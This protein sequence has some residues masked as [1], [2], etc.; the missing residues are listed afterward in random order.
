MAV[1]FCDTNCELNYKLAKEYDL[2]V[3]RMPY[4]LEGIES[5]FDLGENTDFQEF[6]RKVRGGAMPITSGLNETN[7][8]E[9]FEPFFQAGEEIL[10]ISFSSKMS[11]TFEQMDKA[12]KALREK[13]PNVRFER[14]DTKA[15]SMSAGISVY[16]AAKMF[17]EGKTIDEII[18]FLTY[19]APRVNATCTVDD[20]KHLVKGGRLSAAAAFVG[21]MLKL[22]PII[23]LSE[24]GVLYPAD[25]VISRNKALKTLVNDVVNRVEDIDK[26]PIVVLN[27]DC[28]AE[29]DKM[30]SEIK[31]AKP[32]ADIWSYDVGPVVGTHCGPGTLAVCFVAENRTNFK[33][34]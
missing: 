24:D 31:E 27:A 29:A 34:A 6:Y 8:T 30:I 4:T 10:Y 20:L 16:A 26:Y 7:Y 9:Y 28:K 15:I 23:R 12:V 2:K 19:F 3:I 32:D 13:Y 17:K 22:K 5:Y 25:K 33:K 14:F 18:A 21:G 1:L 11:A